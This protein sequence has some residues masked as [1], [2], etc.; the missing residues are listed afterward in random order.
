MGRKGR[1][2][3]RRLC[4]FCGGLRGAIFEDTEQKAA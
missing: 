2:N 3:S 4:F 1:R